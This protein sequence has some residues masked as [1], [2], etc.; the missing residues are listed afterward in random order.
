MNCIG[1]IT[2]EL[3]FRTH[4]VRSSDPVGR[5]TILEQ[6]LEVRR[7]RTAKHTIKKVSLEQ[8][9]LTTHFTHDIDGTL[10]CED[11]FVELRPII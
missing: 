2:K 4:P 10:L 5:K 11:I 9:A 1:S 3:H 6:F 8:I 7:N